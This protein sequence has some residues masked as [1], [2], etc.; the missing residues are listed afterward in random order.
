MPIYEYA[1]LTQSI[2]ENAPCAT[3]KMSDRK[4]SR[5][6]ERVTANNRQATSTAMPL[7]YTNTLR[8]PPPLSES[9]EKRHTKKEKA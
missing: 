9:R 1:W 3:P 2:D 5:V 4:R 8:L 6:N 7:A